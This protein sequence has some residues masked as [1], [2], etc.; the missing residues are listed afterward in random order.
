ML[1]MNAGGSVCSKRLAVSLV[2]QWQSFLRT[3]LSTVDV[4]LKS[5]ERN[6]LFLLAQPG[7]EKRDFPPTLM[8]CNCF[9]N[10]GCSRALRFRGED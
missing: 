8:Y 4:V 9:Y 1:S 7:M 6:D 5:S 10:L 2:H 3:S